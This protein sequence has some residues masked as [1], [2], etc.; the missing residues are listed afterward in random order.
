MKTP[1]WIVW[2]TVLAA[3]ISGAQAETV[4]GIKAIVHDSVITYDEVQ[5][6]TASEVQYLR[7]QYR[8]DLPTLQ[9]KL[10][11]VGT[12]SLEQLLQRQLILRDFAEA[13]YALPESFVDEAVEERLRDKFGGDR[14]KFAK[15]LQADG[16][17]FEKYRQQIREQ[18]TVQ[19]LRS[20]NVA[21][22]I[23]MSPHKIEKYYLE[24]RDKYQVEDEVKLRMIV[25]NK[26]T[27]ADAERV[28][29]LAEEILAKLKEGAT[30]AEMASVY[31]QGSQR[32]QGGDW[33][34]VEKSVLKKELG[35]VAFKLK[36]GERSDIIDLPEACYLM[37]VEDARP[38]HTRPL[39]EL[40]EEIE[41]TLLVAER[42]RLDDRYIQ[43]L[44]AKTFVRYF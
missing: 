26:P 43:K 13:G 20:K 14:A 23:I 16:I 27:K 5:G 15:T 36:A 22:E 8:N 19:V 30:F 10:S 41:R 11:E 29:K 44:K 1:R 35:E 40:R 39:S 25:L 28:H 24:N 21:Q 18:I 38:A 9:A 31:S 3:A 6:M 34:W 32:S 37:L 4:N 12:N 17:T 2:V 33:G 42:K 7:R